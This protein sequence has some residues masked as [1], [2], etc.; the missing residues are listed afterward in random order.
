MNV[1]VTCPD[2]GDLIINARDMLVTTNTDT[3]QASVSFK[4]NQCGCRSTREIAE[5]ILRNLIK[6][7]TPSRT[8]HWPAELSEPRPEGKPLNRA[9]LI[10]FHQALLSERWVEASMREC[11]ATAKKFETKQ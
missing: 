2:C 9:D 6:A 5:K 4:C 7:G 3:G 8:W 1:R 11:R 10:D